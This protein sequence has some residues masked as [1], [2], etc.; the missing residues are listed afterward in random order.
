MHAPA[1]PPDMSWLLFKDR[2]RFG[3]E[4]RRSFFVS[5]VRGGEA[6]WLRA[7]LTR[8]RSEGIDGEEHSRGN[9]KIAVFLLVSPPLDPPP[10]NSSSSWEG[11]ERNQ[12]VTSVMDCCLPSVSGVTFFPEFFPPRRTKPR[13]IRPGPS[14]VTSSRALPLSSYLS[15]K[16]QTLNQYFR[17]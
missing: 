7:G 9:C 12:S 10:L 2:G 6:D 11:E 15:Q 13:A 16:S 14:T 1:P 4:T 3:K 5:I 8:G 17:F